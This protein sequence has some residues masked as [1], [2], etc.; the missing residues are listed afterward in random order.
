MTID[1]VCELLG[2]IYM[3]NKDLSLNPIIKKAA[4]DEFMKFGYRDASINRIAKN[5]NVTTG[6]LYTRYKCKDELFRSFFS[7][8]AVQVQSFNSDLYELYNKALMSKEFDDFYFALKT[9]ILVQL[10]FLFKYYDEFT[11]LLCKSEGSSV[12]EGIDAWM[13]KKVESTYSFMQ[14]ISGNEI[15]K[16]LIEVLLYQQLSVIKF[17]LEKGYSKDK[18]TSFFA[19]VNLFYKAG[20][21]N[22]FKTIKEK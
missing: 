19:D 17:I 16:N 4:F 9:E 12:C 21:G 14:T 7:E 2:V 15:D 22:F 18:A 20:W 13:L 3:T 5:A 11:L 10:D 8:F 6:A 1:C